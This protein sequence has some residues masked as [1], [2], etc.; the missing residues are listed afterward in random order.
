MRV[1]YIYVNAKNRLGFD[2]KPDLDPNNYFTKITEKYPF[3]LT[4]PTPILT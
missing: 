1:F 4:Y 3:S 2:T